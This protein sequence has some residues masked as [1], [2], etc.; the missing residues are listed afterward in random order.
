MTDARWE[1]RLSE[2]PV[3]ATAI[4]AG[5]ELRPELAE[6]TLLDERARLREEDPLTDVLATVGDSVFVS[7]VSRFEVDLNRADEQAV[8]RSPDDAWGLDL[9][10]QPP[11][12]ELVTASLQT[13]AAFYQV[14]A[15]WIETTLERHD[16]VL[17]LDI[18]SYNHRRAGAD[19]EPAAQ[20][21]NPDIDLGVTTA[22]PS[23]FGAV[24]DA[25]RDA[26]AQ[27]P[28]Q[29]RELDVRDNVRFV[30]GGNFPEWVAADYGERVCTVTLE[31]KKIFMD[32]WTGQLDV[33]MLD[34]LRRGLRRA[35]AAARDVLSG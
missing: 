31:Y 8:Y 21:G 32:E 16:T 25:F 10:R 9:W 19:G 11:S 28:A 22:D 27:S 15:H 6:L 18:H 12:D 5:H 1:S 4:H 14:M 33:L 34:D 3:I 30:D 26:L 24:L 7:R 2:G 35:V 23:R 17:L 20:D 29:G 13:H